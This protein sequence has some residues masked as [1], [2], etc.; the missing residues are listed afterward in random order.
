[1]GADANK[2]RLLKRAERGTA[3]S[4]SAPAE[5]R[6][7]VSVPAADGRASDADLRRQLLSVIATL[8]RRLGIDSCESCGRKTA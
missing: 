6:V 8:N 1:M 4:S 7:N 2:I 5:N 3:E